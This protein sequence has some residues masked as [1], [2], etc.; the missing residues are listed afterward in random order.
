MVGSIGAGRM[1]KRS[2]G[3]SDAD[4]SRGVRFD[5]RHRFIAQEREESRQRDERGNQ[6]VCAGEGGGPS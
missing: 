1:E 2:L 3:L 6:A 4:E 5:E